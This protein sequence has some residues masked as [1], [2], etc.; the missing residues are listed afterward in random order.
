MTLAESGNSVLK[1]RSQLWLLEAA[2]D[3]MAT[4]VIQVKEMKAFLAQLAGS[5][6]IG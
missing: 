1:C 6:G 2:Q 3:D 5:T 4:K